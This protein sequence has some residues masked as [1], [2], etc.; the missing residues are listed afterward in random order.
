MNID[1]KM[2]QMYLVEYQ[3]IF[4]KHFSIPVNYS[5]NGTRKNNYKMDE[6]VGT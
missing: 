6:C 2:S 1:T 3:G 4:T 5:V